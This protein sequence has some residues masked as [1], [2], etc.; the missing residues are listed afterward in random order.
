MIKFVVNQLPYY[1][2]L[3]PLWTMCSKNA[4]EHE[5]INIKSAQMK[6]HMNVSTLLRQRNSNKCSCTK[7]T[8]PIMKG[9]N[10][11]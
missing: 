2:E 6:T 9:G 11:Q 1:G 5:W 10:A 8:P 7:K 4:K 3:C